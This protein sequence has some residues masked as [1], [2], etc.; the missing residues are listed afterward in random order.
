MACLWHDGMGEGAGWADI[1]QYGKFDVDVFA[2][3][4][5]CEVKGFSDDRCKPG[6]GYWDGNDR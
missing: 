1:G 3:G 6:S 5:V 4:M 2:V